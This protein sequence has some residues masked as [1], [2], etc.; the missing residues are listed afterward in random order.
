MDNN[1]KTFKILAVDDD[2]Y[3]INVL[4]EILSDKYDL[5][6][7]L[8]GGEALEILKNEP[9]DLILLDIMMPEIDGFEVC[10]QVRKNTDLSTIK[11]ILLSAKTSLDDKLEGYK[12][13]A[14]DYLTKPFDEE[15][16]AA[17][18]KVYATLKN[19]EDRR[20]AAESKLAENEARYRTILENVE[21]GYFEVNLDGKLTFFNK[22]FSKIIGYSEDEL[23]RMD[24]YFF[25]EKICCFNDQEMIDELKSGKR[26]I[27]KVPESE[28]KKKDGTLSIVQ[29]S[30]TLAKDIKGQVIGLRGI[31]Y[32]ITMQKLQEK[33]LKNANEETQT[34]SETEALVTTVIHDAKKFTTAMSMSL[35]GL[36]LPRLKEHL[37]HEDV[38]VLELLDD[39]VEVHTNSVRCTSFLES[40]LT[41][42]QQNEKI[43]SVEIVDIIQQAISLQSYGL[44]QNNIEWSLEFDQ[45]NELF[46]LGNTHL[47]RVFMNLIAN[48]SDALSKSETDQAKITIKITETEDKAIISIHNNG[49]GIKPE[50]LVLIR[51]G[52]RISTKGKAGK[53]SGVA[54]AT[55]IVNQCK[56]TISIESDIDAGTTVI[57]ELPKS[58]EV[59]GDPKIEIQLDDSI[60]LF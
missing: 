53:G 54:G 36:I 38:W 2:E 39:V 9:P 13:G 32:D 4:E 23:F 19:E 31:V 56:G 29:A 12:L 47:I 24:S 44:M 1:N 46:I 28:L 17:K 15:E 45:V 35:E 51:K 27:V 55:K 34:L 52:I 41:I 21:N 42:N 25:M 37:S 16:L 20:K 43:E 59:S 26:T 50:V 48:A 14:N 58:T 18:I 57:V 10:K 6:T 8:S 3:N 60:E 7:V 5:T 11:I 22:A 30:T 33:E 40:L 49:P